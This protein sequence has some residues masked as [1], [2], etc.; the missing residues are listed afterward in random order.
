VAPVPDHVDVASAA[1]KGLLVREDVKVPKA[2]QKLLAEHLRPAPP[3]RFAYRMPKCCDCDEPFTPTRSTQVRC[4]RCIEERK[5]GQGT[6]KENPKNAPEGVLACRQCGVALIGCRAN[7]RYCTNS[8]KWKNQ[9][10]KR[11]R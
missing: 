9:D 6:L 2:K 11:R 8:C 1:R 7:R 10:E 5:A 4:P 3:W